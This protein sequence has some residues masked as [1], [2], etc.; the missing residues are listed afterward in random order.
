M[1]IAPVCVGIDVSKHHLDLFDL[2]AGARRIAN[3]SEPLRI[4]A[5]SLRGRAC[6]V[7]FEATGQYDA[8]LRRSLD[9]AGVAYARINPQQARDFA[10]AIG[11][12]AKTD[13][14]DARML[15]AFGQ[16]LTPRPAPEGDPRRAQLALWHKRRDQL[17]AM[18]QQE[19]TRL[20]ECPD[21]TIAALVAEHVAA[22]G[23]QIRAVEDTLRRL[24]AEDADLR[25]TERRLRSVPGIGPVTALTLLALMPELGQRPPK[26]LAALAGLAP[27]NR[28]SGRTVG[29]RQVRGGRKRVRDAL[30]MAALT[31]ARSATRL[32]AF[33]QALRQKGKPAKL[34]FIALARKI[35]V[36]LNAIV[37]DKTFFAQP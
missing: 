33:C 4:L 21:P 27:F 26:A 37:R 5:E 9:Q 34:A 6:L 23:R 17:V 10:K 20:A 19:R 25:A 3:A 31:A 15:A 8:A 14:L 29:P 1:S 22:L 16:R 35:L 30:Y 18:R 32:G 12:R 7:V 24:V 11:Q 2:E 36:I 28:D 13:P